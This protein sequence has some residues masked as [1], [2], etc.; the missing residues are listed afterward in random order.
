MLMKRSL[1][2]SAKAVNVSVTLLVYAKDD[3]ISRR[4]C[5]VQTQ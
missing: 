4:V 1:I 3:P 2:P 5:A